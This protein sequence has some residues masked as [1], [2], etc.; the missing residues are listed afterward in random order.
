MRKGTH[1]LWLIYLSVVV[2]QSPVVDGQE[3][4]DSAGRAYEAGEY[5]ECADHYRTAIEQGIQNK[6]ILYNAACCCALSGS[7][8]LAFSYLEKA[9]ELG[10]HNTQWIEKDSDLQILHHDGRWPD[11]V[12]R[13]DS[14]DQIY[15]KSINQ[16]LYRMYQEDQGDRLSDA[17][18]DWLLINE[19]DAKHRERA[20]ALLDSGLVKTSDDYF[21][22][23]MIFQHGDDSASY[24]LARDLALIAVKLDSTNSIARWLAAAA[25]DRYLWSI[26]EPQWYGT[27]THILDGKWTIDPVDTTA[28]TDEE[29]R[30]WNVPPLAEARRRAEEVNKVSK[31]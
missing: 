21:H 22:A 11:L 30:K 20:R 24:A 29:R 31:D 5:R 2:T 23:A 28:V 14:A 9:V 1:W 7:I 25:K 13:C 10:Y 12:K 15:Q 8:D 4:V 3:L 6:D 27:Q 17:D 16:E 18:L 19:R 26:G